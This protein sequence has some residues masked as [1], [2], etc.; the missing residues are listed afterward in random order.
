MEALQILKFIYHQERDS[1]NFS[2]GRLATEDELIQ[3]ELDGHVTP[4]TNEEYVMYTDVDYVDI[5]VH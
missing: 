2:I 3:A 4:H 5:T 1:L